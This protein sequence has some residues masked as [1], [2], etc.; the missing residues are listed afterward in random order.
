MTE[1]QLILVITAIMLILVFVSCIV[2]LVL[3]G[4]SH[5]QNYYKYSTPLRANTAG[6]KNE[7]IR[8]MQ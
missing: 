4:R 7:K 6:K 2:T 5:N 3:T 1:S 8:K